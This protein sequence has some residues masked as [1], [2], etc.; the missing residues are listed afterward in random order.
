MTKRERISYLSALLAGLTLVCVAVTGTPAFPTGDAAFWLHGGLLLLILGEYWAE[1][2]FTKPSDTALNGVALFV[3]ISTLNSPPLER[4]WFALRVA[5][6]LLVLGAF[7]LMWPAK[8]SASKRHAAGRRLL[9]LAVTRFGSARVLFSASFFLSLVSYFKLTDPNLHLLVGFWAVVLILKE[10]DLPSFLE[11]LWPRR[12]DQGAEV[13]G[14]TSRIVQPN[15]VR[16]QLQP[17]R[18][19]VRG[20]LVA[21][22]ANG[23][24]DDHAPLA[25]VIGHRSTPS[26]RET[27]AIVVHFGTPSAQLEVRRE[28]IA[29]DVNDSRIRQRL[30]VGGIDGRLDSIIGVA[31]HGSN[32]SRLQIE[33]NNDVSLEEG[34][35]LSVPS[36]Q[37]EIHYQVVDGQ[38][39]EEISLDQSERAFTVATAEQL[40][41][42]RPA[43]GGF[44][45]H[46]WVA[47]E[48]S[49]VYVAS[50]NVNDTTVAARGLQIGMVPHSNFPVNISV[51]ELVLFHSAILGVTGSGKSYL[52]FHLIE[53]CA[54]SGIKVVCVDVSGDYKRC[55][56]G[57]V[58]L[59]TPNSLREFLQSVGGA[60]GIVECLDSR[61]HPIAVANTVAEKASRWCEQNRHGDELHR[62]VPK[63]LVVF[64]EAHTLIPEWNSN[65]TRTLQDTVSRTAQIV[66]QARK[67]GL[68]FMVIT[69]RTANVTKSILNQ[70]NTIFAFQAYDETGFDFMKNYMGAHYVSVLPN[71]RKREGVIVGKA[72]AS[73]RPLIVHFSHQNR[74]AI[75]CAR[76]FVPPS[77]AS[78]DLS[79]DEELGAS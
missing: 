43:R 11:L 22:T 45:T 4:W 64:E 14:H 53:E 42:W 6:A 17:G 37:G 59:N 7:V 72:S 75:T 41:I 54:R 10:L 9:Y 20:S 33:L 68:G 77:A 47:R 70:C 44:E 16:F 56:S 66:L 3:S 60:V 71:L 32:V 19:C 39:R 78:D 34:F 74:E 49:P 12:G 61:T 65:P 28:V 25:I 62:A 8:P 76:E 55:I 13:L 27:E 73:D 63:V 57:A 21:L 26:E 2:F 69:Q 48:T 38:L 31:T 50:H 46:S 23:V 52:A 79:T 36:Q 29:C 40:G 15:L 30:S 18:G 1:A 5:S 24:Y 35:L 51:E 58:L 67:F